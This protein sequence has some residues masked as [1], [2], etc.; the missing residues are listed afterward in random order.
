MSLSSVSSKTEGND[1]DVL[2]LEGLLGQDRFADVPNLKAIFYAG[3]ALI[4]V[5]RYDTRFRRTKV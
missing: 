3:L 4:S 1:V 2:P 5:L